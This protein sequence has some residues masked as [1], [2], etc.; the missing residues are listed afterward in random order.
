M[1]DS[2]MELIKQKNDLIEDRDRWR[3]V[4][5]KMATAK[6]CPDCPDRGW[7][8]QTCGGRSYGSMVEEMDE[9]Q[10]QCQWCYENKDSLFK[11]L[12]EYEAAK[13]K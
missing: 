13:G 5:E 8:V 3:S 9:E 11:A 2:I 7:Y 1:S 10:V 4:A 12:S 6:R